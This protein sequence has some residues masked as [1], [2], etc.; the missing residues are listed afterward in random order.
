MSIML[1]F[2]ASNGYH[3][4]TLHSEVDFP[5]F[6]PTVECGVGDDWLIVEELVGKMQMFNLNLMLV[7]VKTIVSVE[8]WYAYS[9]IDT[10]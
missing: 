10:G 9:V 7:L 2:S 1:D 6:N 3:D 8:L 5:S 4:M